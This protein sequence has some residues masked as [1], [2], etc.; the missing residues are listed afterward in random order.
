MV[1]LALA[2]AGLAPSTAAAQPVLS[3][4]GQDAKRVA[5]E[6]ADKGF[7]YY[8]AGEYAKAIPFLRDAE[9]RF[10]APTLLLMEGNA[11]VKLGLLVEARALHQRVVDEVLAADAPDEFRNAQVEAQKSI[12]SLDLRIARLKIVFKGTAAENVRVTIDDVEIKTADVLQLIP[13]NPGT[14]KVVAQIGGDDG[15]RAVFQSVT[16]KEGTTKQIQLVF[17]PG[18]EVKPVAPQAGGCGACEV[19]APRGGGGAPVGLLA[20]AA[21]GVLLMLRRKR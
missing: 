16:L 7:E 11:H 4:Q 3:A 18:G 14:H 6:L 21:V 12:D 5:R 9:A 8:E 13:Q 20:S 19:A 2:A 15:G 10:H 17:R 1:V